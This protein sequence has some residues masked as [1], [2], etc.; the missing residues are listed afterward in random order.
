MEL[1]QAIKIML[2]T[3]DNFATRRGIEDPEY[4]S[5]QMQVLANATVLV[6]RELAG[7]ERDYEIKLGKKLGEYIAGGSSASAAE[8]R[9]RTELAKEKGEVKYL[10]RIV[11]SA[12]SQVGVSQ[13]RHNHLTKEFRLGGTVT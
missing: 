10:T 5:Q 9:V 7:F 12:W 6:E 11:K 1:E 2:E 8:T 3:Q 4:I 13:S